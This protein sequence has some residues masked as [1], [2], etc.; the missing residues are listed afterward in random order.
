MSKSKEFL[1]KNPLGKVPVLE[2]DKGYIFESGAILRYVA[3]LAPAAGLYGNSFYEQG[4][5]DQWID[6]AT[7]ELDHQLSP[8]VYPVLFAQFPHA[9][10]PVAESKKNVAR[11]LASLNNY[12]Q[13]H[14][15]LAGERLTAA[16]IAVVGSLLLPTQTVMDAAFRKPYA[17]VWRWFN[18]CV[19]QPHF[20]AVLGN[21]VMV[22]TAYP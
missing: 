3:R 19:N 21:V 15:F 1:E 13:D 10:G 5:V 8:W 20:K 12:L 2:T 17:N 4:L 9:E 6:F 11:S 14:T 22:D 18:T 7:T 16:D